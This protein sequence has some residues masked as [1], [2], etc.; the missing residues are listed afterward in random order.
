MQN[1]L[2]K[3]KF[4]SEK[5]FIYPRL[6]AVH[7]FG[8]IRYRGSG[9]ANCL[10]VAARAYL[11]AQT[12]GWIF[13]NPTWGNVVFGPYLRNEKDK[14][15][16]FG[17]FKN[18]GVSGFSKL[19]YL[20]FLKEINLE[21][22]ISGK[23]GKVVIEG[24]GNYFE[25]LLCAQEKVKAFIY[26]ILREETVTTIENVDFKNVIGI[27]I[28]LSDYSP[29]RRTSVTWYA[30]IVKEII[31]SNGTKYKFFV[32]S[33]GEDQELLELLS[34]PQVERA[35]FGNALSDLIALSKCKLIIGSDSTFSGWSAFLEQVPIIFPKRHFGKVLIDTEKELIFNG[36]F[37]CLRSFINGKNFL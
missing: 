30:A 20:L 28:R 26:S 21:S 16:Y 15:H 22:A 11:N 35:F 32:F 33:D 36:D 24:L 12:Y 5:V 31:K 37:G 3:N 27:H 13:I 9:L 34:M 23:K 8:F 1:T 7:D 25:D 17:L 10:F 6:P 18:T 29:E 14:R 2:F 4:N 19:F